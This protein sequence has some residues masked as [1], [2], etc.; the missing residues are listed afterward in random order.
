MVA[1][2]SIRKL[3]YTQHTLYAPLL[4]CVS[5]NCTH[6]RPVTI[7]IDILVFRQTQVEAPAALF[8]LGCSMTHDS[9]SIIEEENERFHG[10]RVHV[11]GRVH[12][13][14][15]II[16]VMY[17]PTVFIICV[18]GKRGMPLAAA[19]DTACMDNF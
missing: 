3:V 6:S 14:E 5:L 9:W 17:E 16:G 12:D 15:T 18:Q 1:Q 11:S 8:R 7:E 19:L 13:H 2:K 4:H 10:L